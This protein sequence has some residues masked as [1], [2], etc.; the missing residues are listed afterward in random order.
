MKNHLFDF[1]AL[2]LYNLFFSKL[3]CCCY[4][5]NYR[6]LK[7]LLFYSI[8]LGVFLGV[9]LGDFLDAET[10]FVFILNFFGLIFFYLLFYL[11]SIL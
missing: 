2:F 10:F 7:V 5:L 6:Q 4:V 11:N 1:L 8:F 3:L 9:F